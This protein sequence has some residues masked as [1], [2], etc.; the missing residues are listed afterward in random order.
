M[1][2]P[3]TLTHAEVLALVEMAFVAQRSD[4][5]RLLTDSTG[6]YWNFE[7]QVSKTGG[8]YLFFLHE[9]P[10]APEGAARREHMAASAAMMSWEFSA[11][12]APE[13]IERLIR[14]MIAR[15]GVAL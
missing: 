6:G 7:P 10:P 5:A 1:S 15:I 12:G 8:P 3:H 2:E 11:A 14:G 13:K 4:R 9:R